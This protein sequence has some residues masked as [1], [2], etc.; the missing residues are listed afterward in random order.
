MARIPLISSIFDSVRGSVRRRRSPDGFHKP[1]SLG[2]V[3]STYNNPKWLEKTLWSYLAQQ[4]E[5]VPVEIILADDGS[6]ERTRNLI[7]KYRPRFSAL[8]TSWKVKHV[9]HPDEGFQKCRILNRAIKEAEAEYLVFTDQDCL[10]R[11]DYLEIH[12]HHAQRGYFLSGGYLK[13]SLEAS[14]ELTQHDIESGEVFHPRWLKRHVIKPGG[15]PV[16]MRA[17]PSLMNWLTTTLATWN[18]NSSSCWRDDAFRING[19]NEA[20]R[21]GGEDREFGERLSNAG[22]LS[23]QLRYSL[24]CIHL[25]HDRPYSDPE[26]IKANNAIRQNVRKNKIIETPHGIRRQGL[27]DF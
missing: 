10:A 6:D 22:L 13:I 17:F 23:K 26:M 24:S 15:F 14:E 9:W 27:E 11:P 16:A 20:M 4:F 25:D 3:I 12:Y 1:R 5:R 21:Y 7:D 2:V 18:G 19:F 8:P